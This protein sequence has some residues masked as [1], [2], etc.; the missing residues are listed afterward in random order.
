MRHLLPAFALLLVL[1]SPAAAEPRW[2]AADPPFGVADALQADASAAMAQDGTVIVARFA[3]DGALEVRERPPGGAYGPV[4][5]LP[6][7]SVAPPADSHLR[8]LTGPDGTA[9]LVFDVGNVRY[10]SVR[11]PGQ[12]WTSPAEAAPAG[13]DAALGPDGRLWLVSRAPDR[14]DALAV[15]RLGSRDSVPLLDPG[16]RE[17]SPAITVPEADRAHVTFLERGST[18]GAPGD[19]CT[20][21]SKIR[22]VDVSSRG[23]VGP[24][25]SVALAQGEGEVAEG[26]CA[27]ETGDVLAVPI[28]LATD[29]DGADTITYTRASFTTGTISSLARHRKRGVAWPSVLLPAEEVTGP[30][31]VVERLLGGPG[32]PVA[33]IR[34]GT[35]WSYATRRDDGTWT[36][37]R[38]LLGD[39]GARFFQAARAGTGEAVFA[40]LQRE[41]QVKLIGRVLGADGTLSAPA[42]LAPATFDDNLLAVGADR[43][44]NAV[45]LAAQ[46]DYGG[47]VLRAFGYDA[48]GPRVTSLT[49]PQHPVAGGFD[50]Y[51]VTGLDVWSGP[52]KDAT[53]AF[54]DGPLESGLTRP[55]A[56]AT[57]GLKVIGVLLSDDF[58]NQSTAGRVL[59]V[60]DAP[61]PPGPVVVPAPTTPPPHD[62]RAP[63]LLS[64]AVI[65]GTLRLTTD[66][67]GRVRVVLTKQA[68]GVRRGKRCV[69][70]GRARGKSCTR[71]LDRRVVEQAIGAGEQRVRLPRLSAGTWRMR[72]VVTDTAGNAARERTLQIRR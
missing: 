10:A 4:I 67:A 36:T 7:V 27:V 43:E 13:G 9:A 46:E 51:S 25:W 32:A 58:G 45:A 68:R 18:P 12:A 41:G 30:G 65:R 5:D 52:A 55:H 49:L 60:A 59:E 8:V 48:A 72:L 57:A 63:R 50:L 54:G 61:P 62:A 3:P 23:V 37:P 17:T 16:A 28:Q 39:E 24:V 47:Y 70:P 34:A 40:W 1:A 22:E 71:T 6:R 44:G 64:F 29:A 2:F 14:D 15:Y 20:L 69:A 35:L 42:T 53:W 56:F 38:P 19:P 26:A 11:A 66:E 31:A 21:L 33:A